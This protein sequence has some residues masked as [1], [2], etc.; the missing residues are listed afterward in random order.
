MK[1]AQA[2]R[3]LGWT[4]GAMAFNLLA[5]VAF[6]AVLARSLQPA[7]FGAFA[8]A[9]LAL[10]FVSVFAQLGTV[11]T[12]VQAPALGPGMVATALALALTA[13]MVLYG[14][15]VALAPLAAMFFQVDGLLPLIV[16]LGLSLPLSALGAVPTA[17][18]TR[19]GLFRPLS[20]IEI[21]SYAFGF[22]AVAVSC[23]LA[24]L[25]AWSLVWGSLAQQG[26]SVALGYA[27]LRPRPDLSWP[28][29]RPDWGAILRP[30]SRYSAIGFLEFL[31]ASVETLAVGRWLGSGPLGVLNRAQMLASLPTELAVRSLTRVAFPALSA[32]QADRTRMA[33]A[34]LVLLALNGGISVVLSAGL[35]AAAPDVVMA[36]LGPRWS[37][38]APVM[39]AVALGVPALFL[40][41]AC[42]ITLDSLSR[43]DEKLRLQAGLLVLKVGTVAALLPAGLVAVA[44]GVAFIEYL[45][46]AAGLVLICRVL[47]VHRRALFHALAAV[48]LAGLVVAGA[49]VSARELAHL[50]GAGLSAG[51]IAQGTALALAG[52]LCAWAGLVASRSWPP[53]DSMETLRR[54]R[55]GLLSW[56]RKGYR[57]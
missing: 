8:M 29:T 17:L 9:G 48:F 26:L 39:A 11:Q 43:L 23:A 24:G 49:V 35:L 18:L 6:T 21:V 45:R 30:G 57:A 7:D 47:P 27:C 32:I 33:D 40:Y 25:G 16:A 46:A 42:G 34:F 37:E 56:R 19:A 38:A 41:H 15:A 10:R 13:S 12:L 52:G 53:L 2:A 20:A 50:A 5:Q 36:L 31:W 1:A 4:A 3:G 14:L 51:L 54:W 22:G 44:F 55:D 28:R